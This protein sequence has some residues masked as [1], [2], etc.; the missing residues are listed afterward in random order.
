M[1]RRFTGEDTQS[2]RIALPPLKSFGFG[3][4][5]LLSALCESMQRLGNEQKDLTQ[6]TET[7]AFFSIILCSIEAVRDPE[8]SLH[9]LLCLGVVQTVL[10]WNMIASCKA[11]QPL[12]HIL[13]YRHAVDVRSR[14]L[15]ESVPTKCLCEAGR[16][17]GPSTTVPMLCWLPEEHRSRLHQL[18]DAKLDRRPNF[19]S[20]KWTSTFCL[21]LHIAPPSFVVCFL[22]RLHLKIQT[23]SNAR[24][25]ATLWIFMASA[26]AN[27]ASS[28][29][30]SEEEFNMLPKRVFDFFAQAKYRG[31]PVHNGLHLM[32]HL[33][34]SGDCFHKRIMDRLNSPLLPF[35]LKSLLR[36]FYEEFLPQL[37][38][39]C[40][41]AHQ[42]SFGICRYWRVDLQ[43]SKSVNAL[44]RGFLIGL[45]PREFYP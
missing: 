20:P 37:S 26:I 21:I 44:V 10:S 42:Q 11:L 1:K 9:D 14:K 23:Q 40:Y 24:V 36:E 31:M 25:S 38:L 12:R 33:F 34:V 7:S 2:K 8:K 15:S 32:Q 4:G 18:I 45:P 19:E 6:H 41:A 3:S 17:V 35:H 16:I 27:L 22:S 39:Q 43:D 5:H 30:L 28:A 13:L 29:L